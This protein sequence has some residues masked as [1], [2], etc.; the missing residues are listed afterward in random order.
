MKNKIS[1]SIAVITFNSEKTIIE[2]LNSILNQTYGSKNIELIVSDDASKD[3]TREIVGHW[4]STNSIFFKN[5]VFISNE[6]NTGIS[7]N[8]NAA[9][10]MVNSEW[11][12]TI[13]GDD[14]LLPDCIALNAEE[15]AIVEENVAVIFSLMKSFSTNS[16]NEKLVGDIYPP[17]YQIDILS[18]NIDLQFKY[19]Q[20]GDLAVA[21]TSFIRVSSLKKANYA[22]ERFHLIED[23]PLWFRFSEMKMKLHFM[24][25]LTV[26]YRVG[27]SVTSS[28]E[29]L[30]NKCF[31]NEIEKIDKI[32]INQTIPWFLFLLRIRKYMWP[33][34]VR[35]VVFIFNNHATFISKKILSMV[36]LVKPYGGR[37]LLYKFLTRVLN[38]K[39]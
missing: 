5:T 3:S 24:P 19:L 31:I 38:K 35:F 25:S 36:L 7:K 17:K 13:A 39:H 6:K 34:L 27:E 18:K 8:C 10:K 11:V 32:V 28:R 15:A 20:K 14:I 12:K 33:I 21:P 29:R 22:D 30:V 23:L 2:T 37:R 26:M 16:Q 4:L 1:I 9:W